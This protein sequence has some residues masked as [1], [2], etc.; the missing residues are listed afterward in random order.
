MGHRF[1]VRLRYYYTCIGRSPGWCRSSGEPRGKSEQER[2]RERRERER[3]EMQAAPRNVYGF[4]ALETGVFSEVR[5]E[6]EEAVIRKGAFEEDEGGEG[7]VKEEGREAGR[8]A[9]L[10]FGPRT[11][12]LSG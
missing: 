8:Q 11:R 10:C 3:G 1:M 7:G 12:L 2:E 9:V 5:V 4:R 6:K